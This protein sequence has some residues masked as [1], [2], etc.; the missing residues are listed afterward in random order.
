MVLTAILLVGSFILP[1]QIQQV[2]SF[3]LI[4]TAGVIHGA[5]DLYLLQDPKLTLFN[6]SHLKSL[7]LYLF[8]VLAVFG[9]FYFFPILAL[10]SFVLLSAYHFGEQHWEERL[11]FNKWDSLYYFTYGALIFLMLFTFHYEDT[12]EII[13][14]ITSLRPPFLIFL[15]S[16]IVISIAVF[17]QFFIRLDS[18]ST[19][20]KETF[21]LGLLALLFF[22]GT[23]LFGFGMYFVVWH[24]FPS[25]RSQVNYI[26]DTFDKKTFF[27]YLKSAFIYW[28][29]A[30]LG[31]FG[32]YFFLNIPSDQYLQ[33][34]FSFLAAITFPHAIVMERMFSIPH[35]E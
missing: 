7:I 27:K 8:F 19:I 35:K 11:K 28:I 21:L 33:L 16:L 13:F 6:Y 17:I 20:I 10:I 23:L 1:I 15:I 2:I 14:Q 4:L 25:L 5:N 34:F 26:Y 32:A 9:G 22:R 3:V 24:S 30:L 29:I 18:K 12:T 31:L